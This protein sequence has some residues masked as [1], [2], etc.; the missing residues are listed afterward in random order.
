LREWSNG[1]PPIHG[2]SAAQRAPRLPR[3]VPAR[4]Q[5]SSR[6]TPSPHLRVSVVLQDK[7]LE[8]QEGAL[9]GHMLPHLA[10]PAGEGAGEGVGQRGAAVRASRCVAPACR[11]CRFAYCGGGLP[12]P[13]RGP[14]HDMGEHPQPKAA[15][16]RPTARTC[17]Q[18][19]HTLMFVLA[20]VQSRHMWFSTTNSTTKPCCRM[21]PFMTWCGGG[22]CGHGGTGA[23]SRGCR[24]RA[25]GGRGR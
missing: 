11:C 22:G 14:A 1:K 4:L 7:L 2:A 19:A 9:V 17:A 15:R 20:R 25:G 23:G 16:P 18:A 6:A 21:A 8:E 13:R 12:A 10:G 3:R 5:A 24:A